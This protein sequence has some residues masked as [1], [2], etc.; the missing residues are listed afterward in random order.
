M[1]CLTDL[2]KAVLWLNGRQNTNKPETVQC[3]NFS[4]VF[5]RHA[6]WEYIAALHCD[7]KVRENLIWHQPSEWPR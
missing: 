4:F 2:I 1:L 7:E 3:C 5:A 6:E